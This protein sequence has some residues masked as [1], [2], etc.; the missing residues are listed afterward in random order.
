MRTPLLSYARSRR[1]SAALAIG[2]ALSVAVPALSPLPVRAA[3]TTLSAPQPR[4]WGPYYAPGRYA[5]ATGTITVFPAAIHPL[6]IPYAR[7]VKIDGEVRDLT[8]P[9]VTL[10]NTCGWAMF[11]F[12]HSPTYTSYEHVAT[13]TFLTPRLIRLTKE[14]VRQVEMQVCA[15]PLTVKAPRCITDGTWQ[16]LYI[17]R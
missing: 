8:S 7:M 13:C 1:V 17:A 16:T 12:T 2:L 14:N 4:P 6:Q 10:A 11:R 15:G 5:Q 3:T 9:A